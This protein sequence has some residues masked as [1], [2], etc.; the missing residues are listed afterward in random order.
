MFIIFLSITKFG[1]TS[2]ILDLKLIVI[3]MDKAQIYKFMQLVSSGDFY[4]LLIFPCDN[5]SHCIRNNII[6]LSLL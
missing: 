2:G 6:S 1:H 3:S 5:H 4:N